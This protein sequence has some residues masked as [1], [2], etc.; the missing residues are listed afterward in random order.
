MTTALIEQVLKWLPYP[1]GF[2]SYTRATAKNLCSLRNVTEKE[3]RGRLFT[4]VREL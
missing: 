3:K 4:T 1:S 2:R